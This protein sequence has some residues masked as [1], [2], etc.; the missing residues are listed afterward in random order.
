MAS[1]SNNNDLINKFIEFNLLKPFYHGNLVSGLIWLDLMIKERFK[2]C[3]NF[4]IINTDDFINAI[5]I[6]YKEPIHLYNIIKQSLCS[7]INNKELRNTN[8]DFIINVGNY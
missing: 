3:I 6:S 2:K 8:I 1:K 4:I 5:N 7:E